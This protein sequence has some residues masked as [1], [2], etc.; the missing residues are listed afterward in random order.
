LIEHPLMENVLADLALESEAATLLCMRIARAI[1]D[2]AGDSRAAALKRIGTALA[3]YYVCKRAPQ[4]VGEALE[5]LGGNGYVEESVMP[6]L[7]REAPLNS[8]WEGS[9]NINALDV[10]RILRKQPESLAAWRD[11]IAPALGDARI[12]EASHALERD[13]DRDASNEARARELSERLAVLWEAALLLQHAPGFVSDAFIAGRID[14][15]SGRGVGTL[16]NGTDFRAIVER[17]APAADLV[18]A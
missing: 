5:S 17:A 15:R 4:A 13:L 7:Y 3:K 12:S 1:D 2:A 14:R 9:G 11:E 10:Q 18:N 8:I 6:R 16:P